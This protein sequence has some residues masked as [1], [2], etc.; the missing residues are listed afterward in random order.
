MGPRNFRFSFGWRRKTTHLK[1][2]TVQY[3][4]YD[5]PFSVLHVQ[6]QKSY[7]AIVAQFVDELL[8]KQLLTT[9][10]F[11]PIKTKREK[12]NW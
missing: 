1:Y 3:C 5:F 2:T 12:I 9:L 11:S 4:S 7:V 10:T 6:F 8:Y